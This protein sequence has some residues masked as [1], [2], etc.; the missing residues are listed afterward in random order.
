[1]KFNVEYRLFLRICQKYNSTSITKNFVSSIFQ[2]DKNGNQGLIGFLT[3]IFEYLWYTYKVLIPRYYFYTNIF[4]V[5]I[6]I[7]I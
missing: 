5:P 3:L 7:S 4:T 6:Y 2:S 1:M